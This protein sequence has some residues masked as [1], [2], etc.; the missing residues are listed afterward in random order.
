MNQYTPWKYHPDISHKANTN[1]EG[2][3]KLRVCEPNTDFVRNT[4]KRLDKAY[5]G[6]SS[7]FLLAS[8]RAFES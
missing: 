6:T 1:A 4:T 8:P 3:A 5:R 7:P 2:R